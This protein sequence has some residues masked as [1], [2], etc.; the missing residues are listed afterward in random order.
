MTGGFI[1]DSHDIGEAEELLSATFTK[2]RLSEQPAGTSTRTRVWRTPM[3]PLDVDDF[4]YSYDMEY[5]ADPMQSI[6]LCRVLKG[7]ISDQRQPG[8]R[9]ET[10]TTGEAAAI[11][12][13]EGAGHT[14][15]V[16][17]AVFTSILIDRRM[18]SEVAGPMRSDKPVQL[19]SSAPISADAGQHLVDV[20]D[21]IRHTVVNSHLAQEPLVVSP[22]ARY[23][24]ATMLATF[25]NTAENEPVIH[26]GR[27]N[28][29][30]LLRRATEYIDDNAHAD[31]SPAE[32][33][34]AVRTTP[35]A[36]LNAFR[37]HRNCTPM[38]YVRRVRLHHAHLELVE[39]DPET[40]SVAHVARRWG[41]RGLGFFMRRYVQAY[42][43]ERD[44]RDP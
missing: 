4:E 29:P 12:A 24:A 41:F 9:P 17:R 5:A 31:I 30:A 36:L 6:M 11:G 16:H 27:D 34:A 14:G 33:A 15:H 3:G 22:L 40:T 20:I 2:V 1:I 35:H 8:H 32:I 13:V 28:T 19:T 21:H 7:A 18:L 43:G 38:N 23:L 25:P 44:I 39:S 42:G 10:F 26:G 37:V